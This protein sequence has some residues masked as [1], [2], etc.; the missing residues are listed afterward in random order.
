MKAIAIF[1]LF[2]L[3]SGAVVNQNNQD[4]TI[5]KVVKLLQDMLEK[6]QKE[7]DEERLLYAKFKCYCDTSEAEKRESIKN[8]KEKIELLENQIAEIQGDTGGLSSECA[9]LKEQMAENKEAREMATELRKKEAKAYAAT[10]EDLETAIGQLKEAISTLAEVGADQTKSVGADH[11]QFMAGYKGDGAALAQ[12]QAR[13]Q[14]ALKAASDLMDM[15]QHA[16]TAAF[17]QAPFTGTYTSQS[18]EVLGILKEMRDTFIKNLAEATATEEAAIKAYKA[19][20]KIKEEEYDDMEKSYNAKQK[21]LGNN[22]ETLAAKKEALAAAKTKVDFL[23]TDTLKGLPVG[24]DISTKT[25][26]P[27]LAAYV[28]DMSKA[29]FPKK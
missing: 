14:S 1:A 15:K 7:A 28:A 20:M 25:I 17:L 27:Y 4:R 12:L 8:L 21:A 18:A 13:V 23:H 26:D 5:T 11:K 22:D 19:F 9:K 6:S 29:F 16:K 2:A 3:C 24:R 10:K